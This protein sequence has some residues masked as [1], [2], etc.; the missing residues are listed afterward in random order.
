MKNRFSNNDDDDEM[1]EEMDEYFDMDDLEV[2]SSVFM[3]VAH[4]E[5]V[6]REQ[7][8]HVLRLATELVGK[9]W[10]FNFYSFYIG[11]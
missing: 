1:D 3:D 7:D 6:N 2:D 10:F 4:V 8:T 11:W 5:L 9:S